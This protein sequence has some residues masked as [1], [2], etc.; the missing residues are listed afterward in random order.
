LTWAST[1]LLYYL[2]LRPLSSSWSIG[3]QRHC[4]PRPYVSAAML[5]L[6]NKCLGGTMASSR[7]CPVA[8][9]DGAHMTEQ[10]LFIPDTC[11]R[12]CY[13]P[14]VKSVHAVGTQDP[15]DKDAAAQ[16]LASSSA[17]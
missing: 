5:F 14:A 3:D 12:A 2:G 8:G 4:C 7:V 9:M 6:K 15:A 17:A 16:L 10:Q 13:D 11:P 1:T